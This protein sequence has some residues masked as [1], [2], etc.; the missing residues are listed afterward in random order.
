[1]LLQTHK[2]NFK[3]ETIENLT[4]KLDPNDVFATE[5]KHNI[6]YEPKTY[7]DINELSNRLNA[8]LR[9]LQL[10]RRGNIA[11]RQNL[12]KKNLEA[13]MRKGQIECAI[14]NFSLEDSRIFIEQAILCILHMENRVGEKILKLV[15]IEGA[16]ERNLDKTAMQEMISVVNK[17]VNTKK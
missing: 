7:E 6:N 16:L 1:M 3:S 2:Q 14:T 9:V 11:A 17:V 8:N 10:S 12:L 5:H 15:L 4:L 13:I